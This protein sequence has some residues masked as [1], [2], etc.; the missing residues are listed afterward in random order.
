MKEF[1]VFLAVAQ[2]LAVMWSLI[3]PFDFDD[4]AGDDNRKS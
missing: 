3:L 2:F 1:L 4:D